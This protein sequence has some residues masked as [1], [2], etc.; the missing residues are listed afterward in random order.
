MIIINAVFH[1]KNKAFRQGE[2]ITYRFKGTESLSFI[3]ELPNCRPISLTF[4]NNISFL[5]SLYTI[6]E[7][8]IIT[9]PFVV[10]YATELPARITFRPSSAD[11][12]EFF[13]ERIAAKATIIMI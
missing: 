2:L 1:R 10:I 6:L 3:T 7:L 8:P 13:S 4:A 9:R 12:I 11:N 5:I